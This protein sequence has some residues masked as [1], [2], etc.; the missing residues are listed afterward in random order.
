MKDRFSRFVNRHT[1]A[2]SFAIPFLGVV[3][4]MIISGYAPFGGYSML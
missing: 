1:L 3:I 2:L 4:L